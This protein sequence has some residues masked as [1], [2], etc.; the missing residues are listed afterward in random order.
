ML[1]ELSE[2]KCLRE[3]LTQG[4]MLRIV[5]KKTSVCVAALFANASFRKQ[6]GMRTQFLWPIDF[7]GGRARFGRP[8]GFV[9]RQG[10]AGLWS[11]GRT[12][13]QPAVFQGMHSENV[14]SGIRSLAARCFV[15]ILSSSYNIAVSSESYRK[16]NTRPRKGSL[17]RG[18]AADI[19]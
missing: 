8:P 14:S 18:M 3:L 19:I 6:G 15:A 17:L 11:A 13:I 5:S 7:Q 16:R 10:S 12:L 4:S 2:R 9:T 1:R